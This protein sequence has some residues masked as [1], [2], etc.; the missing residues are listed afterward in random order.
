MHDKEDPPGLKT[1]PEINTALRLAQSGSLG[2]LNVDFLRLS[3]SQLSPRKPVCL[4]HEATLEEAIAC[5]RGHRVG[6]VLIVDQAGRLDGIFSERDCVLKAS[7]SGIDYAHAK[8]AAYMTPNPVTQPLDGSI[9]YALNLMSQGGFRHIPIVDQDLMPVGIISVKDIV[10]YLVKTYVEALL[11][12][13][14]KG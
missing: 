2:A 5:L 9:A 4:T 13:E 8:V 3:I 12:F 6:C 10:D 1:E 11:S 14:M 7:Q